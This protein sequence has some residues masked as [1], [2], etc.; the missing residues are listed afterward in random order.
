MWANFD[1]WAHEAEA[2]AIQR[3]LERS[4]QLHGQRDG[5]DEPDAHSGTPFDA[6]EAVLAPVLTLLVTAVL[7]VAIG[8]FLLA[9]T[10][11]GVTP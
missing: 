3:A 2:R 6:I 4:Q 1:A 11:P 8:A 9:V 7:L 10:F 5:H